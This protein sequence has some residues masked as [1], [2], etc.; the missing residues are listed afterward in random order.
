MLVYALQLMAEHHVAAGASAL[1]V[2]RA[3]GELAL[4]ALERF[5][6]DLPVKT[7]VRAP[8]QDAPRGIEFHDLSPHRD[9]LVLGAVPVGVVQDGFYPT[10]LVAFAHLVP[11][12]FLI[13]LRWLMISN[14]QSDLSM[15]PRVW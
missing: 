15:L 11:P 14:V 13:P 5:R 2:A 10:R 12:S 1:F 8:R 6:V 3:G 4:V 7:I 9:V